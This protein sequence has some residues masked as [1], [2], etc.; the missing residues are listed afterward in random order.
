ME[1]AKVY[2]TSFRTHSQVSMLD[3]L[4]ALVIKAGLTTL[5]LD[6][7]YVAIKIHFGEPGNL[8]YLRPNYARAVVEVLRENGAHP[9]LTD[10]NT[11]YPGMRRN[12]LDHMDA[13]FQNGFTPTQTGCNL[14]I[15]DGL[16]GRDD[17]AVPIDCEYC[18]EA[19]IGRAA[20]DA[21]VIVSL[22]HFKGHEAT[23]IGG[24]LKNLGM[25]LGSAAGKRDLHCDGK[26]TVNEADCIGCGRCA[27]QCVHDAISFLGAGKA[28]KAHIDHAKCVG[29]H[30]CVGA[31][32]KQGA[33]TGPDTSNDALSCKIAE[34]A[35]AVCKDRP[36]FHISLVMDVSPVCDCYSSNDAP[37]I[38]DVGVF[39]S[40]DPVALDTACAEA[41]NKMEPLPGTDLSDAARRTGDVFC[42]LHPQ[43]NWRTCMEHAQKIG[44]GTMAYE[45]I[46]V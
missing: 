18:K 1:K 16:T 3:K 11:M 8:A 32:N 21:D 4:K 34:Y 23:G 43:T 22:T 46:E 38:P 30:R 24:A 31:C 39:A 26:P 6:D 42:D 14:I 27:T 36:S 13:A 19:Y 29:C 9:F 17:V 15:A 41:C 45:L 40:L 33:I 2:Y 37:V 25:G 20:M 10:C 12:A 7:K 44:L 28:R 35:W 5:P